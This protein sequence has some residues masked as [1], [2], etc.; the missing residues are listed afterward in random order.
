[1]PSHESWIEFD[2]QLVKLAIKTVLHD[3]ALTAAWEKRDYLAVLELIHIDC[4]VDL[5]KTDQQR[6]L[7]A[8]NPTGTAHALHALSANVTH[9]SA[10]M[11]RGF[12]LEEIVLLDHEVV[13]KLDSE[14]GLRLDVVLHVDH[15]VDLDVDCE[16]V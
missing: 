12:A 15:A 16:A 6:L 2:W 4:L 11:T 10:A 8:T 7:D 3:I 1:L 13:H 14:V 9:M 5:R